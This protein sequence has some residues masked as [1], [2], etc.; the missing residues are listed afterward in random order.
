MNLTQLKCLAV[1]SLFAVIG[2]GPI[3]PGCLIGMY[4]VLMRPQWFNELIGNLYAN[5]TLPLQATFPP[6][7]TKQTR[8]A[9][10]KCFLS[11]LGLF[12]VDIA[13]VPVTPV[14]A[15]GII[16]GRPLWFY[17]VAANVY[18]KN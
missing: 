6:D 12:I 2:F 5:E 3:S 16:L 17:K 14:V 1:F 7:S 9:R 8:Q 18:G 15:F 4:I 13:P 11:L 10:I